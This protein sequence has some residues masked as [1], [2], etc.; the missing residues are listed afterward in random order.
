MAGGLRAAVAVV[1]LLASPGFAGAGQSAPDDSRTGLIVGQV[2]DAGTGRPVGGTF[3]LLSGGALP[4]RTPVS[5]PPSPRPR[6]MTDAEGRFA[7]RGLAR[8]TYNITASKPGYV[9]GAYGR[10]RPGGATHPLPLA[11]GEKVGDAEKK[12]QE[13]R[14]R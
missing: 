5:S 14:L 11:S 1:V 7:F 13:L 12:M 10:R 3:V 6:L 8:G 9:D 4:P 2:I